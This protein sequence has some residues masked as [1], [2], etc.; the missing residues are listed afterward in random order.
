VEIICP[1]F[2]G[3][4]FFVFFVNQDVKG[5]DAGAPRPGPDNSKMVGSGEN[6]GFLR[7]LKAGRRRQELR[8]DLGRV[9]VE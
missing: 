9:Q 8:Y 1:H 6:W 5:V 4:H 2:A 7:S 3:L